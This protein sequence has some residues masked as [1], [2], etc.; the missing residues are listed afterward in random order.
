[1]PSACSNDTIF[2][3]V[4]RKAVVEL[5][6]DQ[7]ICEND[8]PQLQ[9][10]V[11]NYTSLE[12]STKG[13]GT[14][15]DIYNLLP[16]YTPGAKD[17]E[18]GIVEICLSAEPISPCIIPTTDCK[19][20]I[21]L[22]FPEINAGVDSTICSNQSFETNP[23]LVNTSSVLW[24]Y[25]GDGY[26]YRED[27]AYTTFY[28]GAGDLASGSV[29]LYLFAQGIAPCYVQ[30]EDSLILSFDRVPEAVSGLDDTI[31]KGEVYQLN[32][33]A[34]NNGS[35]KWTTSGDGSF[36]NSTSLNPIYTP[37]VIDI[38]NELATLCL[39]VSGEGS[40][41]L[42][43]VNSCLSLIIYD[44]PV[45][46]GLESQ[47]TLAC[48][49][50]NF[51][52]KTF[53]PIELNPSVEHTS[54]VL[55]NTDGDGDFDYPDSVNAHYTLGL[56]DVWDGGVN[57]WI[58]AFGRGSCQFVDSAIINIVVPIQIISVTKPA[59]MGISS[60]VNKSASTVPEVMAPVVND[61]VI[62]IN[63]QGNEY[64]PEPNPPINKIGNWSPI[65][66]KAKFNA[67]TCLPIYGDTLTNQ[68]FI[69]NGSFTYLPV[70]TNVPTS[71]LTLFGTNNL[72]VLMIYD[73]LTGQIW[74]N[75]AY[76]FQYLQPGKAYLLVSKT[77]STFTVTFPDYNPELPISNNT[78]G[79]ITPWR[80]NSPWNSVINTMQ[81]HVIMFS[82]AT[83]QQLLQGDIIGAFNKMG[84]CV[85]MAEYEGS[86]SFY[87]LVAM[88]DD[89]MTP[90]AEGYEIDDEMIFKM[91][92]QS[93][94]ETFDI[95]LTYNVEYPSS[96]GLYALNGVSMA[97]RLTM[98]ITSVSTLEN[99]YKINVFPNPAS[100]LL[101]IVADVEI[102]GITLVNNVG[103]S[104]LTRAE[105]SRSFQINVSR[106]TP[107]L[108][109]LKIETR[110]GSII[111]K[112]V[113][114][115]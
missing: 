44:L 83:T 2:V 73:W 94:G 1:M 14:F 9:A 53:S 38:S 31:C 93:T 28:P 115:Q 51:T 109:I 12:W 88:G 47:K 29:K 110:S 33:F 5:G 18:D 108:Y 4:A 3:T 60:Y 64:W 113:K 66:Y 104:I 79:P 95:S 19:N 61:L 21:M 103:Q 17:I 56:H 68:D 75:V 72:K 114:I 92:R 100:D 25:F 84:N 54:T 102:K 112:R 43:K 46:T 36:S 97:D 32:G 22:P 58:K 80:N 52:A 65:G 90:E 105:N 87:K 57:L 10:I 76:D 20:L 27:T 16:T 98:N 101:N 7:P 49:D 50:Y 70:L 37:G 82:E 41:S 8:T 34:S 106:Y 42:Q 107:G 40:C 74:T 96:D 13:D 81:P 45:V 99:E 111:I 55:W 24:Q 35:I 71:I 77:I 78:A 39:E 89:P 30:V 63:K 85:G 62:M 59:W 48:A 67:A 15:T 23:T 11:S 26:F 91:Y 69:I 86:D 6:A